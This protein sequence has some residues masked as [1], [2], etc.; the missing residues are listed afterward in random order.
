[1]ARRC[2]GYI[3][4]AVCVVIAA[5]LAALVLGLSAITGPKGPGPEATDPYESGVASARSARRRFPIRFLLVALVFLVFAI[6]AIS[7]YPWAVAS[8]RLGTYGLAATPP[9]SRSCRLLPLRADA[10]RVRL[11]IMPGGVRG[12]AR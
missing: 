10:G 6:E 11:G 7:P 9:P 12:D 1:V 3:P 8:R 2:T 4:I 5:D